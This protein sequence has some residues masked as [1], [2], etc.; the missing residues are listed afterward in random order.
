MTLTTDLY[1][2]IVVSFLP[3]AVD[4]FT[5]GNYFIYAIEDLDHPEESQNVVE[6]PFPIVD[7][8][9][10]YI[11][12]ATYQDDNIL[13]Y[14]NFPTIIYLMKEFYHP[15][16]VDQTE[17]FTYFDNSDFECVYAA[18]G[19][20]RWYTISSGLAL[21]GGQ[22]VL[23]QF[24][25]RLT[26]DDE[27]LFRHI[28]TSYPIFVGS[29]DFYPEGEY[30][31]LVSPEPFSIQSNNGK[32]W[33]GVIEYRTL[34]STWQE[35]DGTEAIWSAN[36][37]GNLLFIRGTGNTIIT[38][39][40]NSRLG[41]LIS[42]IN[43]SISGNIESLL[44]HETVERGEH[45]IMDDYCFTCWL[46][47]NHNVVSVPELTPVTLS[48]HCYEAMFISCTAL[49]SLPVLPATT[50]A[51]FCYYEMFK[52]CSSIKLSDT[53]TSEYSNEYRIP[54]SGSGSEATSS[55]L[56][57]FLDAGGTFTG[58]PSI[59]TTYYTSNDVIYIH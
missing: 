28:D 50:L 16:I 35:W 26:F 54:T 29:K 1:T 13:N 8:Q 57:M 5:V 37:F 21:T 12:L 30:L 34:N 47:D 33:D 17:H 4:G 48:N 23:F 38:G 52:Y 24:G 32:T 55:L 14:N 11:Y 6:V 10:F 45:P 18:A 25:H 46:S 2:H 44:D 43:V 40:L 42:G 53:Q 3:C 9:K 20:E 19:S 22:K 41:W 39:N 31:T 58:T 15:S 59:N 27:I 49:S 36:I 7:Y 56:D 51:D